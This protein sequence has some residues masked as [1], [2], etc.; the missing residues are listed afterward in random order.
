MIRGV[1]LWVAILLWTCVSSARGRAPAS[2][3]VGVDWS[4]VS[5]D[6]APPPRVGHT[7]IWTGSTMLIWGGGPV[8]EVDGPGVGNAFSP[9]RDAWEPLPTDGAPRA[10][11]YHTAIWTEGQ[12]LV[13]G[14]RIGAT[15][16]ADLGRYDPAAATWRST[17]DNGAPYARAYHTAVWTGSE[18]LVWGGLVS[19]PRHVQGA[20]YRPATDA[21]IP[22]SPAGA[23]APRVGHTAIW[24]GSRMLIWGGR[25]TQIGLLDERRPPESDGFAYDPASDPWQP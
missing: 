25:T 11:S 20:R 18:M 15:F 24:T 19:G 23:P 17:L 13:W 8:L 14:G 12:L 2:G 4:M 5:R 6:R 16:Y 9:A 10:R 3:Q 21:W 22:L 1:L 7:A